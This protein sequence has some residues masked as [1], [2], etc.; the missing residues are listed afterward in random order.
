MPVEV[1]FC[2][3]CGDIDCDD[4]DACAR[5]RTC[6]RASDAL[7]DFA[8]L[9]ENSYDLAVEMEYARFGVVV[10]TYHRDPRTVAATWGRIVADIA[11]EPAKTV[12][13]RRVIARRFRDA[14]TVEVHVDANVIAEGT[15]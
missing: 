8:D 9:V 10:G 1:K 11:E 12:A 2:D 5:V 6:Q 4:A 3:Q 7:R 13:G 14:L 15:R